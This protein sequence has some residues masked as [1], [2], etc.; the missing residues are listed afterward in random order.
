MPQIWTQLPLS[1][2]IGP[3]GSG[4]G[5]L[6]GSQPKGHGRIPQRG[7]QHVPMGRDDARRPPALRAQRIERRQAWRPATP[8]ALWRRAPHARAGQG[9]APHALGKGAAS[10]S[11]AHLI[12]FVLHTSDQ[13]DT[14]GAVG[15]CSLLSIIK[16]KTDQLKTN[17]QEQVAVG[18]YILERNSSKPNQSPETKPHAQQQCLTAAAEAPRST[19][20][21]R[22]IRLRRK[23]RWQRSK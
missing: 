17:Q 9:T 8:L 10:A 3:A 15:L 18:S 1:R 20:L 16:R 4:H 22:S 12:R 2:A 11:S 6:R 14:W 21:H 23:P 7:F 13:N 19:G 5:I